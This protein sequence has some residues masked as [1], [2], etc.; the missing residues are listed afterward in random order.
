MNIEEHGMVTAPFYLMPASPP[1]TAPGDVPPAYHH[2]QHHNENHQRRKSC[3]TVGTGE[4]K[5]TN[6]TT[7]TTASSTPTAATRAPQPHRRS[8]SLPGEWKGREAAQLKWDEQFKQQ[9]AV[10]QQLAKL[11]R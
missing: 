7:T 3:T 1:F 4:G 6:A 11:E 2:Q 5:P 8:H 10:R 9:F